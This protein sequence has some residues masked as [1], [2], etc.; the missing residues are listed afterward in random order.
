MLEGT[1]PSSWG[2]V[3]PGLVVGPG[4]VGSGRRVE[5]DIMKIV[6]AKKSVCIHPVFGI[7]YS[8]LGIRYWV[9]GTGYS[10]LGIQYSVCIHP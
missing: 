5:S 9:F 2:L 8:V 4:R 1:I 6:H 10:E 7:R 3:G